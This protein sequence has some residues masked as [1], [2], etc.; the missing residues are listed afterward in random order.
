[1][2][3]GNNTL[4][5][6]VADAEIVSA[7]NMILPQINTNKLTLGMTATQVTDLTLLCNNFITQYGV[8]NTAK[9]TAK[10]AVSLKDSQKRIARNALLSWAKAWRANPAVPDSLLELLLCAPHNVQPTHNPP[11]TPTSLVAF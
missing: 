10:S 6:I 1:M 5:E 8:A 4:P 9:A 3:N 2:A 11:V 7:M